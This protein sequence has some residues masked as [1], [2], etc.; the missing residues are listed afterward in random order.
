[1]PR[2]RYRH[3]GFEEIAGQFFAEFSKVV[4]RRLDALPAPQFECWL[5]RQLDIEPTVPINEE[6][7][8]EASGLTFHLTL[9]G[10]NLVEK[11]LKSAQ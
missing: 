2:D 10:T 4:G 11:S 1:V 5:A 7:A 9:S 3:L 6:F 8:T